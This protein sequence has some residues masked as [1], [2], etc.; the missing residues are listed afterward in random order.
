MK[1]N[2][3]IFGIAAILTS[4]IIEAKPKPKPKPQDQT[5]QVVLANFAQMI[6]N[7]ITMAGNPHDPATLVENGSSIINSITNIA[8]EALKL[9]ELDKLN[10]DE[11]S[12]ALYNKLIELKV[13]EELAAHITKLSLRQELPA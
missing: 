10:E 11:I 3:V 4:G 7:L 6:I 1:L 5:V 2:I 8:Q 12:E 9:V 13:H